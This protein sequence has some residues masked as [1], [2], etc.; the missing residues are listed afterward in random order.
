M[1]G[2][3]S[4]RKRINAT[5]AATVIK[6]KSWSKVGEDSTLEIL[7]GSVA[8][9]HA[10]DDTRFWETPLRL[11]ALKA[12]ATPVTRRLVPRN[13]LLPLS[14]DG[15]EIAAGA[16]LVDGDDPGRNELDLPL[17]AVVFA[18]LQRLD[19]AEIEFDAPLPRETLEQ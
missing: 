10:E 6:A 15:F 11:P 3:L 16:G 1:A 4:L 14:P 8:G 5:A 9:V 7:T 18:L 2:C 12:R 17:H 19:I 13:Q